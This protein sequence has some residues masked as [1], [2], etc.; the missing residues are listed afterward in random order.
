MMIK[1]Q[2]EARRDRQKAAE[3]AEL[4]PINDTCSNEDDWYE[5]KLK[6]AKAYV[7]NKIKP[8]EAD[9]REQ[10]E[11]LAREEKLR[12]KKKNRDYSR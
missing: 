6:L 11:R 12:K 10:H 3:H 9:E 8:L 1:A 5:E 2:E 7:L 4:K